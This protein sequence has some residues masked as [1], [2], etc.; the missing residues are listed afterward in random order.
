MCS[1]KLEALFFGSRLGLKRRKLTFNFVQ[2]GLDDGLYDV[3][4]VSALSMASYGRLPHFMF[5][6]DSPV[7]LGCCLTAAAFLAIT[8]AHYR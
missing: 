3:R 8:T 1:P 5:S 7:I 4:E 2:T 6:P